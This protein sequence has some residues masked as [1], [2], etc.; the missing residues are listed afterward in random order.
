[1][2][3]RTN[4]FL[5]VPSNSNNQT[6]T[7]SNSNFG[8]SSSP[9]N[10]GG[11]GHGI[12]IWPP[13]SPGAGTPISPRNRRSYAVN[14]ERYPQNHNLHHSPTP[15]QRPVQTEQ[16]KLPLPKNHVM[17]TLMEKAERRKKSGADLYDY[18]SDSDTENDDD[19][20]DTAKVLSGMDSYSSY[21]GT[22]VVREKD[23][24][25]VFDRNPYERTLKKVP[26]Y[27]KQPRKLCYGQRV[28]VVDMKNDVFKLARGHGFILAR[29]SQLV[30]I[31]VPIE[32]SCEVEGLISSIQSS[33]VTLAKQM[34][35]LDEA[36]K[37]LKK[38]LREI[39]SEPP[40]HPIIEEY[41]SYFDD[42]HEDEEETNDHVHRHHSNNNKENLDIGIPLSD[43]SLTYTPTPSSP[44]GMSTPTSRQQVLFYDDNATAISDP[45]VD[46]TQRPSSPLVVRSGGFMCGGSLFPILRRSHSDDDDEGINGIT[47]VRSHNDDIPQR[48]T[49]DGVDFRTGLSG[50]MSLSTTRRKNVVPRHHEIRHMSEH[51]GIGSLKSVRKPLSL[52]P[53]SGS[54]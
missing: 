48:L 25:P 2:E 47:S 26:S 14:R 33:K 42:I 45:N 53:R 54:R 28:Q 9:G 39:Q 41:S 18:D 22:Y 7:G 15:S 17:I 52:S 21:C 12:G 11:G 43:E 51:R 46:G 24:L 40:Y 16:I 49:F 1:M 35:K 8:F 5:R 30:K 10:G 29:D 6:P 37:K 31:G 50:H 23:G 3:C 36:E 32:N 19:C 38:E 20:D 13:P 34:K 4:L 27:L 44:S